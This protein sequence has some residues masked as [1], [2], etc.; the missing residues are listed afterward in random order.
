MTA[1]FELWVPGRPRAKA[2]PRL[3]RGR[4]VFTPQAT[5]DEEDRIA[6][7]WRD[8]GGPVFGGQVAVLV[9]YYPQGQLI[10][11]EQRTWTSSLNADL[12][13]LEKLSNDA[14]QKAAFADDRHV[15]ELHSAKFPRESCPYV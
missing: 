5:T 7:A 1:A 4:R 10:R 6:Q 3:G 15:V 14:L 8:A 12:D 13:N 9:D 11:V 2:R